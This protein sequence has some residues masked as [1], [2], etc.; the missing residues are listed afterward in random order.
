MDGMLIMLQEQE[1]KVIYEDSEGF[2]SIEGIGSDEMVMIHC[3][4]E[5]TMTKEKYEQ[6]LLL[7]QDIKQSIAELGYNLLV[8]Q[9]DSQDPKMRKFWEMFGFDVYPHE[10]GMLAFSLLEA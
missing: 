2:V 7:F 6:W 4:V 5:I 9:T 10:R 8:T 1:V 3:E